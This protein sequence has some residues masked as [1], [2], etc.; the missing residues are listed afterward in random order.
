MRRLISTVAIVM[1]ASLVQFDG[2][3]FSPLGRRRIAS[4]GIVVR[5]AQGA[6][7]RRQGRGA[8]GPHR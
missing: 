1:V 4:R 2:I 3:S 6:W 7:R 8:Q 5:C